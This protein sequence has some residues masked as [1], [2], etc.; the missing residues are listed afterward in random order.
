[1]TEIT[2]ARGTRHLAGADI[3]GE[4]RERDRHNNNISMILCLAHIDIAKLNIIETVPL[5]RNVQPHFSTLFAMYLFLSCYFCSASC[6]CLSDVIVL[7]FFHASSSFM[8]SCQS[9]MRYRKLT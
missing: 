6:A 3:E 5:S 9:R 4:R 2:H 1:M 7:L 8:I